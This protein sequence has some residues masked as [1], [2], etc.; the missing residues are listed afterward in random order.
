MTT[1]I[2]AVKTERLLITCWDPGDAPRLHATIEANRAYLKPWLPW[3][4]AAGTL[5]ERIDFMRQTRAAFD[6]DEDYTFGVFTRDTDT[7]IGGTG[8]HRRAGGGA[9]E[10]GY[11]I[12]REY[13][14]RGLATEVA[15]ALTVV[16]L[17]HYGAPFVEIRMDVANAASAAIPRKL[18]YSLDG[19]LRRRLP[20]SGGSQADAFIWSLFGDELTGSPTTSY[21]FTAFDVAGDPVPI[22][23]S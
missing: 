2:Y 6:R 7:L 12:A 8:L 11:W 14:G 3:A 4:Q 5:N 19:R 23:L 10:I 13:A 18:G 20:R 1:T 22:G 21:P 15:A 16:G 9:F 17:A